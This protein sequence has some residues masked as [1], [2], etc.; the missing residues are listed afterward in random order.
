MY[1]RVDYQLAILLGGFIAGILCSR[2]VQKVPA[3]QLARMYYAV[4]AILL[5]L[6]TVAFAGSMLTVRQNFWTTGG[7]ILSDLSFILYGGLFGLATRRRD[8]RELLTDSEILSALCMTLA[9]TFAIAGIAKAFSMT[10]M[11]EFFSQSGYSVVFLKFIV[12][13]EVFGAIGL[14]LPWAV[15]T[16]LI[17]L[18]IDMFG[19]VV[20]HVH[21]GDPLNDSTGAICMLIRLAVLGVL[22][23]LRPWLGDSEATVRSSMLTVGV[24]GVV[25]LLSAI[26]GSVVMRHLGSHAAI[27]AV[28]R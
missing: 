4:I 25:C 6:R 20:T 19:A 5:V 11:T 13:A 7:G 21:N 1:Y 14:L 18:T 9:F 28:S 15:V 27:S 22:W 10:P 17:G 16:A 24:V 3:S 12:F 23:M 2:R 26:G 8:S